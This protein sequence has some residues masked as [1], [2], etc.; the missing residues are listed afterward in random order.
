M[1]G[2]AVLYLPF[3][4]LG[5]DIGDAVWQATG[6][7]LLTYAAWSSCRDMDRDLRVRVLS[8]AF[9]ISLPLVAGSFT[10]GQASIHIIAA[11]WL[12]ALA[13][14]LDQIPGVLLWTGIAIT[15]PFAIV[16]ILF[17]AG[18][19][20]RMIPALAGGVAWMIALPWL[21][22]DST[23]ALS[24][25]RDC[26]SILTTMSMAKDFDSADF[27]AVAAALHWAA[28]PKTALLIRC[29]A[30][31]MTFLLALGLFLRLP[32][33]AAA[34][35]VIVLGASYMCLFNPR[36]EAVTYSILALPCAIVIGVHLCEGRER[37]LWLSAAAILVLIGCNGLSLWFLKLTQY[38]YRPVIVA[39]LLVL[40]AI[41]I[42]KSWAASPNSKQTFDIPSSGPLAVP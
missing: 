26:W 21:A 41:A 20:P 8:I 25:Y 37:T 30:A 35:A 39:V 29:A 7:A 6:L 17:V 3:E 13:A 18:L 1:P 33:N 14:F 2:F 12:M 10:N 24:L 15:K 5:Q 36:T 38:W 23:Y 40:M 16:I 31:L 42:R 9:T 28:G 19:K 34:L 27:T 11:C 32:R 4:W 22:V